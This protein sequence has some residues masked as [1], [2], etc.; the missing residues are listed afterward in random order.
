M[1]T[2]RFRTKMSRHRGSKWHGHGGKKKNRGGGSRGGRGM[3]GMFKH[4]KS[5]AV[6]HGYEYGKRGFVNPRAAA[7][8]AINV[9]QIDELCRKSGKK[10]IDIAA[11]GF[12]KVLAGGKMTQAI[13]VKAAS[14]TERAKEKIEAA[15][16][17]L[18]LPESE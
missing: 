9:E 12:D 8:R 4:K 5:W 17:K 11:L 16:G 2:A 6:L 10:E 1:M 7:S 15:G 3:S 13:T 14:A 18:V